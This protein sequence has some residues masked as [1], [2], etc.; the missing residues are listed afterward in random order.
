ME[1]TAPK[2]PSRLG[3][4]AVALGVLFVGAGTAFGV[5]M[6]LSGSTNSAVWAVAALAVGSIFGFAPA[7]L[8]VKPDSWGLVVFGGSIARTFAVLAIGY[9]IDSTH[10][11]DRKAFWMSVVA[12]AVFVLVAETIF[13]VATL[14][15]IERFKQM[16]SASHSRVA[17]TEQAKA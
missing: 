5:A 12:G 2:I 1:S 8:S 15:R 11:L 6:T 4:L 17:G 10:T 7:V 9:A 14:S 16:N 13:A 3:Y